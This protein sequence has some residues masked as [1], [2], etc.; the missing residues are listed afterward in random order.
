[1][2]TDSITPLV[3]LKKTWEK[4]LN[5]DIPEEEWGRVLR[6]L[7]KATR[8]ARFKL[9]N[10]YV[11]HQAYLT[12]ARINKNFG[13]VTE[14]CPRCGLIGAEFSHMFWGCPTLELF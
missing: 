12:P 5:R 8:N 14:C 6:N 10:F 9:L 13:K 11:L 1:M 4:D 7:L 3:S 2:R